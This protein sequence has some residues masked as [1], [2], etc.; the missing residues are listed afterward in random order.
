[1]QRRNIT[2]QQHEATE[3]QEAYTDYVCE[4]RE[5]TESELAMLESITEIQTEDAVTAAIDQYTAELIEEGV[6]G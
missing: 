5:I 2:E 1:M 4:S 6:L 3:T